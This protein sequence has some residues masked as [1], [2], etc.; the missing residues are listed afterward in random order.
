VQVKIR[1]SDPSG[2]GPDRHLDIDV[3]TE[4]TTDAE[5]SQSEGSYA[6]QVI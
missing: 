2:A 6:A 1:A 5:D 3:H 4:V